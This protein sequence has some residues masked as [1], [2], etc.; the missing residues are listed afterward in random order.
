MKEEASTAGSQLPANPADLLSGFENM[1]RAATVDQTGEGQFMKFTKGD[2][3]YGA[4]ST[5][6]EEESLWAVNP[7]SFVHGYQAWGN[8]V[9]LG[10][11]VAG[12]QEAPI[13]KS[14]LP[15]LSYVHPDAK[16][17]VSAKWMPLRGFQLVCTNGDDEGIQ[18]FLSGTSLGLK[19]AT[20]GLVKEIVAKL[21]SDPAH[22]VPIIEL[23]CS[24]YTHKKWGEIFVPVF[25]IV[26][27]VDMEATAV[28][29]PEGEEEGEEDARAPGEEEGIGADGQNATEAEPAKTTR[30]RGRQAKKE[31]PAPT[32]QRRT[33]KRRGAAS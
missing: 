31:E 13:V 10:E 25:K 9:L 23:D 16:V 20:E 29:E 33:R 11:E 1:E 28:P 22:P 27:W 18:C 2:Y 32:S 19:K 21:K 5:E 7:S 15:Q 8:A 3:S 6:I 17:E 14:N 30:G 4:D 26:E 24:S 12:M